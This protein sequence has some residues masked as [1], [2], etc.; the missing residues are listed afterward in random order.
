MNKKLYQTAGKKDDNF[1]NLINVTNGI[2]K[3]YKKVGGKLI[4]LNKTGSK[5]SQVSIGV[6]HV[7]N[8]KKVLGF[9]PV[10]G[11]VPRSR[12]SGGLKMYQNGGAYEN[13]YNPGTRLFNKYENYLD[14]PLATRN[15]KADYFNPKLSG[16]FFGTGFGG[17]G[18][19]RLTFGANY[20]P[21]LINA[22]PDQNFTMPD[23][24]RS[25]F[26]FGPSLSVAN[27]MNMKDN[28]I[29]TRGTL[30]TN[31]AFQTPLNAS[32]SVVLGGEAEIGGRLFGKNMSTQ[33]NIDATKSP[34]AYGMFEGGLGYYPKNKNYGVKANI[35]YG[36]EGSVNPGLSYG[37]SGNYGPLNLSFGKMGNMGNM[38]TLGLNIP[39]GMG[40]RKTQGDPVR[41]QMGGIKKYQNA[42][43]YGANTLSAAGQG[44]PQLGTTSTIIGQETDPT[45]QQSRMQNL[46]QVGQ[47]LSG[48]ANRL[49]SQMSQEEA[50]AEQRGEMLGMQAGEMYNQSFDATA[51]TIGQGLDIASSTFMPE[52][53]RPQG[54]ISALGAA[55]DAYGLT[56][57]ANMANTANQVGMTAGSMD[58]IADVAGSAGGFPMSSAVDGSTIIADAAGNTVSGGSAIGSGAKSLLS[59]ANVLGTVADYGGQLIR[60]LSDDDDPTKANFG[61]YAGST[62]SYAGKGAGIGSFFPGAGTL[63]GAGIGAAFGA[64][65]EF[66]G[67][68]KAQ[69]AEDAY[70]QESRNERNKSI[71]DL[72]KRVGSAYGSAMNQMAAGNIA[73]KTVSGQNLGRNVMYKHGGMMMRMPRYGYKL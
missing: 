63:I 70:I 32:G 69:E 44:A 21:S 30:G 67:A 37:I 66:F 11:T 13:P 52:F 59:N 31:T 27:N 10:K 8:G 23:H 50:A 22:G 16:N 4:N 19:E 5:E 49:R 46:Q 7:V 71:Y 54:T 29:Q 60:N 9:P 48:E 18:N 55:R 34:S 73:Q 62:L 68:K 3:N 28:M 40:T 14:M 72:N 47:N 12:K 38:G 2:P 15:T 57:A 33:N 6:Y 61:E 36:T 24:P 53:E 43:M 41:Q 25:R 42:G 45:L 39:I 1:S 17:V 51:G 64:G 35:G 58:A 56:K 20:N 65:K 26:R